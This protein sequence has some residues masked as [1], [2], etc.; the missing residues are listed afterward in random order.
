M[1][2]AQLAEA[3][4]VAPHRVMRIP[5]NVYREVYRS[6][7]MAE[8]SQ[9][10][11]ANVRATARLF[12]KH[13][14]FIRS[15]IRWKTSDQSIVDDLYQNLF[16]SLAAAPIPPDVENVR[17]F[18]YRAI[19]NDIVDSARRTRRYKEH[20]KKYLKNANFSVNNGHPAD[21]LELEERTEKL[22]RR[23]KSR[24]EPT[25]AEAICL[26]YAQDMTV[27]EIAEK[28]NVRNRSVSRYL[29]TGLRKMRN[30]ALT[31]L[32]GIE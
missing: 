21:A 12:Q 31:E 17:S 29:T 4:S 16:L 2:R 32:K 20:L 24:L 18:L 23:I 1:C 26:K 9:D 22:V 25:E 19:I 7:L 11:A 27:A 15:V 13:G 30:I 14:E 28:M 10:Y 8:N 5:G 3:G 6:M